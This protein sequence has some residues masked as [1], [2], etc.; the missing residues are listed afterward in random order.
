MKIDKTG[1]LFVIVITFLFAACNG[2]GDLPPLPQGAQTFSLLG[3]TLYTPE[4]PAD[5]EEEY[6]ENLREAMLEYRRDPEE[7]DNVIWLGRRT[8]YL[9]QYRDAVEI[10]TEGVFKHP[11]DP[12]MY[13]HRGHRYL[14]L[15]MFN[16]AIKD[17]EQAALLMRN[18]EDTVEPDGLPNELNQPTST[19]KSNVWYHLGLVHYL[20]AN[21]QAAIESYENAL[22]LDLTE[23]MR[24]AT[25]YWYYMALKRNGNDERAGEVI[26]D[27]TPEI[28]VIENEAYLN[29]LLVF[30]GQF[31]AQ[32]LMEA[33]D[34]ALQNATLG[35]GIG[36]WHYINGREDRALEIWQQIYNDG[37]WP[38]FGFIAAE[39][40][41][42]RYGVE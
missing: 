22:S 23:D 17:F 39:A 29:L 31:S 2:S 13:R 14:T 42:A 11:D 12:R 3:D 26:A 1:F 41:L 9:G 7:P 28:E 10:F 37:N 35:Y 38:A 25:L 30:N 36:N 40:E 27:I 15:R 24:I 4:L 20:Q 33:S 32:R 8:A 16:H 18:M 21:Y 6:S 5:V 34:D 19:L